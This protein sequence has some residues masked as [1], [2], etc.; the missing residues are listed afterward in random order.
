MTDTCQRFL[1]SLLPIIGGCGE[2]DDTGEPQSTA[3]GTA[4]TAC[5]G[6]AEE[7]ATC[8]ASDAVTPGELVPV[9][10]GATVLSVTGEGD[11][12]SDPTGWGDTATTWCCYPV[13]QTNDSGCDYGRPFMLAGTPRLAGATRRTGWAAGAR[14]VLAGLPD[15]ARERLAAAWRHAALDEHAAVAAF[16][17]LAL[18]LLAFGAPAE[19]VVRTTEAAT[20]EVHHALLGFQLASAYAGH[21]VGPEG[22]PLGETLPLTRDLATF[23]AATVKEGCIGETL[24][25][26]LALS[27]L[28]DTTDPAVRATLERI[29]DDEQGHARLAWATVRWALS[30][31]GEPVHAAVTEAFADLQRGRVPL[32]ER[33]ADGPHRAILV[34]HGLPD[35]DM[36][37]AVLDR[38]RAEVILPA[39][40]VLLQRRPATPSARPSPVV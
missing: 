2:K 19:L 15:A 20:E 18:E 17:R 4:G 12:G 34:A 5:L 6:V 9:D 40:A 7:L 38:A 8:P 26:L 36:A 24:T 10:C 21:P 37:R 31:G 13:L 39:A 11:F 25:T 27:A 28:A 35:A 30:V 23:A 33:L 16:S 1:L 22:F 14:P 29:T 32:P 3:E